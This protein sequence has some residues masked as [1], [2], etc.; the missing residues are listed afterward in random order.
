ME[1]RDLTERQQAVLRLIIQQYIDAAAPVSSKLI[2]DGS[3]LGVSS[4][5]IRNEMSYLEE[6][7]YVMQPHTS[8]GRVP[9][10]FGYR[11][12][13]EKLMEKVDL[14]EAE[15]RMITHQFHQ[16]RLEVDQWLRLCAAVLAHSS[17][18]AS[19]VTAPKSSRCYVKHIEL[20]SIQA[21]VVLLILVLQGGTLKQQILALDTPADQDELSALARRLTDLWKKL[22]AEEIANKALTLDITLENV[23]LEVHQVVVETM[24]R[25]DARRSSDT[26]HDGLLNALGQPEFKDREGVEQVIR[27]L[28]ERRFVEQLVSEALQHAGVQII[29]GGEGKWEELSE[30][31]IVLARYGIEDKMSG[32]MGVLGPVRMPYERTVSVVRYMSRLMSDLMSDLY[33]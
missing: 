27:A 8:A 24:R 19:L 26:Y 17:S 12:F 33:S 23:A 7:G 30:V 31:S 28:E 32:A 21:Q 5:T 15:Q 1:H 10:E 13:V 9:T 14:P 6:M 29:I 4:A 25:I 3:N 22:S 11:Y 16:S 2:T 18:N 20:I